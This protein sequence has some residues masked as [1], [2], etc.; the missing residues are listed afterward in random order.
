MKSPYKLLIVDDHPLFRRGVSQL[1]ELDHRLS[2]VAEAETPEEAIR[3]I[4]TEEPDLVLLDLCLGPDVHGLD[5]LRTVRHLRPDLPIVILTVSDAEDD[6][7]QALR[8]GVAGYLLKNQPPEDILAGIHT[9]LNGRLEI[10]GRLRSALSDALTHARTS[11]PR[12]STSPPLSHREMQIAYA[13]AKG[14]SN[15]KIAQRL[16]ISDQT[17][18]VHM[19]RILKRMGMRNRVELAVWAHENLIETPTNSE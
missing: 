4:R 1:V 12:N 9:A 18:K 11:Q 6:L 15:K 14:E 2:L 10:S 13:V 16:G 8:E 3:L 5:M 19:K 7:L 17:V